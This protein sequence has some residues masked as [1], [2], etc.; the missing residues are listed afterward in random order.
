MVKYDYWAF[1]SDT[2]NLVIDTLFKNVLKKKK[3]SNIYDCS[4]SVKQ[5]KTSFSKVSEN[6]NVHSRNGVYDSYVA[7]YK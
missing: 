2:M 1:K 4:W 3:L 6:F 7:V 5:R